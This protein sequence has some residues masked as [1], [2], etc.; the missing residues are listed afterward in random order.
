MTL[1]IAAPYAGPVRPF[2]GG[3]DSSGPDLAM[4][5]SR[6]EHG[7]QGGVY[8]AQGGGRARRSRPSVTQITGSIRYTDQELAGRE[9]AMA[10]TVA[11]VMVATLKA[12]GVRRVYGVPGD[13]LNGFTDAL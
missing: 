6:G 11:D 5:A 13:S 1:P 2:P 9:Q 4:S 7:Y 10:G 8:P 12:S 3:R